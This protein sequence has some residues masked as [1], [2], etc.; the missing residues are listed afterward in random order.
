MG[1]DL[2][3]REAGKLESQIEA[4]ATENREKKTTDFM[5]C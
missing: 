4:R 2:S 5:V 3:W 1:K